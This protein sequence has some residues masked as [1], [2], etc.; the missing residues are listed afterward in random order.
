MPNKPLKPCNSQGCP[1]LTR[2]RYCEDHKQ[3][4]YSYDKHRGTSAQRGY[5]WR[6]RKSRSHFLMRYPICVSCGR[7]AEV[8][9]HI[10]PHKGDKQL[11]WSQDNWQPMCTSCHNAKTARED[12]GSW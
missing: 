9:D 3:L 2:E 4:N 7:V 1:N 10:I 6:W 8:V 5:D 12:M 11:F